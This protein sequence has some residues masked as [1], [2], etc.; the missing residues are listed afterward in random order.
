MLS[1]ILQI[2]RWGDVT[3]T[4][5]PGSGVTHHDVSSSSDRDPLPPLFLS[6]RRGD[7]L[8][9]EF[10]YHAGNTCAK[11]IAHAAHSNLVNGRL[12]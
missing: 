6:D 4:S 10:R 8:R 5:A 11:L 7:T 2:W 3:V 12:L 9:I 1:V